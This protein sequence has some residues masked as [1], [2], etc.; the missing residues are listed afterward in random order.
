MKEAV[1]KASDSVAGPPVV[2]L[3]PTR[4][5]YVTDIAISLLRPLGLPTEIP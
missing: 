4:Y 5:S 3:T 2:R 1:D